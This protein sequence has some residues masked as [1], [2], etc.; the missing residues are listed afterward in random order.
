MSDITM[1]KGYGCNLRFGC[2]RFKAIPSDYQSYFKDPPVINKEEVSLC[3]YFW[4]TEEFTKLQHNARETDRK[5]L[6]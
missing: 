2:Y 1:C 3:G 6:E 5:E 4:P